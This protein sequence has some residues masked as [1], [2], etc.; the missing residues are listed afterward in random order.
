MLS[1]TFYR[2]RKAAA[3]KPWM[4]ILVLLAL[5]FAL[6]MIAVP[7]LSGGEDGVVRDISL[8]LG[9]INILFIVMFNFI[10]FTGLKNGVVGFSYADV[11][12]HLAGPFTQRFNLVIAAGGIFRLCIVLLWVL[13][14]QASVLHMSIGVNSFDMLALLLGSVPVFAFGYFIA[15]FFS[16]LFWDN[17]AAVKKVAGVLVAIDLIYASFTFKGLMDTYGSIQAVRDLGIRGIVAYAGTTPLSNYY[18][19]AGWTNLIYSGI[20]TKDGVFIAAGV[21]LTVLTAV[22]IFIMYTK[23]DLNYYEA[24][25]EN[26]QK[27]ADLQEAK[28]AGIDTDTAKVNRK[29]KVGK[30]TFNKGWGASV[31]TQ[32][33]LFENV[34]ASRLF[35]VNPLAITY[36][37]ITAV[38]M[39][40]MSKSL[41]FEGMDD[42][43][44]RSVGPIIAGVTMMV[45]LNAIVYGG[46]K[47][48]LEF[49]KPF[50]FMVP[51]KGSKKLLCCLMAELPEMA[52]DSLLCALIMIYFAGLSVVEG[53]AFGIMMLVFD[54]LFELIAIVGIRIFR[55]LGRVLLVITR[56]FAGYII[57]MTALAPMI[58]A[59][60]ISGSL[61]L[62][63]ISAAGYGIVLAGVFLAIARNTVDKVELA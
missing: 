22:A 33:H 1:A 52:F 40:F 59:T 48:V 34:R 8:V 41:T 32:R 60:I 61:A 29:I 51:E 44:G 37:L 24:A 14:C 18:P 5:A 57:I 36:R 10:F 19:I 54:M 9:G 39:L 7:S 6:L 35:F 20:L 62:G 13:C 3:K 42:A 21:L 27:V 11:N 47:T 56:Y 63:F 26:A 58:I 2:L 16:A 55:Q 28:K 49:N 12:F 38:Y 46:G 50:I 30:E 45:I 17:E 31:F 4:I 15:A 43:G 23:V 53:I 25:M